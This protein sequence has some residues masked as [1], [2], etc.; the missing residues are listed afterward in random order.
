MINV[1]VFE[2][3]SSGQVTPTPSDP[4]Q[5]PGDLNTYTWTGAEYSNITNQAIYSLSF[6]RNQAAARG[7]SLGFIIGVWEPYNSL[8]NQRYEP[9]THNV[10]DDF[11]WINQ[12]MEQCRPPFSGCRAEGYGVSAPPALIFSRDN[13]A[14]RVEEYNHDQ[15]NRVSPPYDGAFSVFVAYNPPGAPSFFP[16]SGGIYAY[17]YD[18]SG[19]WVQTL[20]INDYWG[21]NNFDRVLSHETGHVFW[22]CDEYNAGCFRT[23]CNSCT[24]GRGPRPTAPNRNCE[25]GQCIGPQACIM[26]GAVDWTGL[27]GDTP[28][29][30][31]W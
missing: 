17:T 1:E 3:E 13:V 18:L 16:G 7:I 29:Q 30:I 8:V 9:I 25:V 2:V 19:P 15:L 14:T 20:F 11:R 22:A 12:I 24:R 31:G 21:S 6:W 5:S 27:C 26:N 10:L 4:D 28:L 23:G